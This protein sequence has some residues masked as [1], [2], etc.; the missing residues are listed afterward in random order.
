MVQTDLW[1]AKVPTKNRFMQRTFGWDTTNPD[2]WP[3]DAWFL[4]TTD[5]ELLQFKNGDPKPIFVN[6]T[7]LQLYSLV[8]G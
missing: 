6:T 4:N 1:D 3:E 8:V 2:L 7:T 5:K